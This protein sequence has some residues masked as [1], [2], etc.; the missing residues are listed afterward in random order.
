MQ[1]ALKCP[2]TSLT[3][4][5][6]N[7][8]FLSLTVSLTRFADRSCVEILRLAAAVTELDAKASSGSSVSKLVV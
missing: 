8:L 2:S 4:I 7:K 5:P 3:S 6:M 1:Y